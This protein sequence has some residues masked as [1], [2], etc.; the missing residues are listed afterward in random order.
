[1]KKKHEPMVPQKA[2]NEMMD[3]CIGWIGVL[4]RRLGV[5]EYRVSM[6]EIREGL[7]K[8]KFTAF[9]EGDTYTIRLTDPE[10]QEEGHGGN[11][12]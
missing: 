4:F 10:K 7:G 11:E 1:M 5:G 2:V 8:I 9:R 12:S 6:K 3:I